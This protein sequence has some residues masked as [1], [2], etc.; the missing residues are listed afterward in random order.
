MQKHYQR[1]YKTSVRVAASLALLLAFSIFLSASLIVGA[2]ADTDTG[3]E[4]LIILENSTQKRWSQLAELDI[5]ANVD[6]DNQHII[7]PYSQGEYS[8]TVQNTARFPLR[9]VM[10][11]SEENEYSV[12]MEFRLRGDSGYISGSDSEWVSCAGL[13][14]LTTDLKNESSEEYMLEWRWQGDVDDERDTKLGIAAAEKDIHY[15]MNI[16]VTAEQT[17]EPITEPTT[18][19]TVEPTTE[20]T[21]EPTT[22]PTVEPTTEP[23]VEPTVKP[24]VEP[25]TEPTVEPTVKPTVEPTTEPTVEPTTEPTVEPTIEPTVG[26]TVEP[27]AEPTVEPTTMVYHTVDEVRDLANALAEKC[28]ELGLKDLEALALEYYNKQYNTQQEIDEAYDFLSKTL[29]SITDSTEPA[30]E[31]TTEPS[32]DEPATDPKT[33]ETIEPATAPQGGNVSDTTTAQTG[34]GDKAALWMALAV[35][36]A[37]VLV[38]TLM[39]RRRKQCYEEINDQI[40]DC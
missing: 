10:S 26:P 2:K 17:G 37:L 38:L 21:A 35:V 9:C 28:R 32:D 30:T 4:P 34:D 36:S 16:A 7:A 6:F 18:E 5:F 27:T 29:S 11:F 20:P 3:D 13:T 22:E 14:D 1:Q 19:P 15:I 39:F 33:G 23:T 12:P 25:T 24:T 8:F 40:N 31:P